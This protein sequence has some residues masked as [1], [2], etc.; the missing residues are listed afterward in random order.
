[1]TITPIQAHT[2]ARETMSKH[3]LTGWNYP[4]DRAV[5]R[6]GA[7]FYRQKRISM[8]AKIIAGMTEKEFMNTLLHE[9]AHALVGE[10]HGHDHAWR[11][12][13][14]ELG[15]NGRRQ[16]QI[17]VKVP[18]AWVGVCPNGHRITRHRLTQKAKG[19]SCP[20]CAPTFSRDYMFTWTKNN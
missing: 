9:I 10:D 5:N 16:S 7:C 12:K 14:Y 3:G 4:L 11:T 20:R 19:G 17:A 1:M 13:H 2:I 8:S 6:S 18:P 15:G